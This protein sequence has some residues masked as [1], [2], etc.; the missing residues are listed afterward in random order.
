MTNQ[1]NQLSRWER[2]WSGFADL[3]WPLVIFAVL[4]CLLKTGAIDGSALSAAVAGAGLF[5]VGH[6]IHTGSKNFRRQ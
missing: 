4:I 6:G 2:F 5:A 3:P 1:F